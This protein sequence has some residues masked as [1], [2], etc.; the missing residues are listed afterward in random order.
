M[1]QITRHRIIEKVGTENRLT[2]VISSLL[3]STEVGCLSA[4]KKNYNQQQNERIFLVNSIPNFEVQL[5][6]PKAFIVPSSR[7][8]PTIF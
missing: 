4:K 2:R 1:F 5:S 8:R 7:R 3:L 6:S